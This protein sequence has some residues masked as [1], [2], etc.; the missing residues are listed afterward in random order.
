MERGTHAAGRPDVEPAVERVAELAGRL[1]RELAKAIVGQQR[2]IREILLAFLAGG[3]CLLRGVP[4]LAKTT[5][6]E[7]Q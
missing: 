2:V 5:A 6:L 3:H 7:M 1:E 4:G